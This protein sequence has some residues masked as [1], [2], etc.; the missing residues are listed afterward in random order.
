MLVRPR[1]DGLKEDQLVGSSE[2]IR[3]NR[4]LALLGE[5]N[6]NAM[7]MRDDLRVLA[8]ESKEPIKI[9]II[10]GGGNVAVGLALFSTI[11]SLNQAGVPIYTVGYTAYSIA[12]L[13]LAAGDKGHR[14]IAPEGTVMLHAASFGVMGAISQADVKILKKND[15]ILIDL[16][17]EL[18]GKTPEQR[19]DLNKVLVDQGQDKWFNAKEAMEFGLADEILTPEIAHE[20]FVRDLDVP[21]SEKK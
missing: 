10:S 21:S 2:I 11:R 9:E 3:E 4:T 13:I 15:E 19:D 14:Y 1:P 16:I 8:R 18:T 6:A 20:L 7:V 5:V 17:A 12:A